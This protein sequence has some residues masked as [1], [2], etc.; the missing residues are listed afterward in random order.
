MNGDKKVVFD[1]LKKEAL[2]YLNKVIEDDELVLVRFNKSEFKNLE[3]LTI[4]NK[5]RHFNLEKE[6]V[7]DEYLFTHEYQFGIEI[8][9]HGLE[10]EGVQLPPILRTEGPIYIFKQ[11]NLVRNLEVN[12]FNRSDHSRLNLLFNEG[13]DLADELF[14]RYSSTR[15]LK[16][17]DVLNG[18]YFYRD[19]EIVDIITL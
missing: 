8:V 3:S 13:V 18:Y 2:T 7:F 6:N 17:I 5:F 12:I 15:N 1:S 9:K 4:G 16:K 11:F 10:V 19:F 14:A